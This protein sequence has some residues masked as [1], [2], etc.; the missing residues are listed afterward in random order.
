MLKVLSLG[1]GVQC[2]A[3]LLMSVKGEIERLD[4][5]NFADTGWEPAADYAHL[6]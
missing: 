1:A 5:A 4:W 2:T 6:A 3:L